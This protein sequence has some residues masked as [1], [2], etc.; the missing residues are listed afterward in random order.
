NH[1]SHFP[2]SS[3]TASSSSPFPP[4]GA[5]TPL[6]PSPDWGRR[7]LSA[8]PSPPPP[9]ASPVPL[10]LSVLSHWQSTKTTRARLHSRVDK[11]R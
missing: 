10:L 6:L 11:E 5:S 9:P 8:A 7:H 2:L 1:N 4:G 3:P